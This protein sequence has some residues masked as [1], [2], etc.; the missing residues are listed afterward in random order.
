M[1]LLHGDTG[2]E[3]GACRSS[4]KDSGPSV[5][6]ACILR[7]LSV[8]QQ[9][10]CC[11]PCLNGTITTFIKQWLTMRRRSSATKAQ[12]GVSST[13]PRQRHLLRPY[14]FAWSH[15]WF[16]SAAGAQPLRHRGAPHPPLH[17]GGAG[18]AAGGGCGRSCKRSAAGKR[19]RIMNIYVSVRM[20]TSGFCG[21]TVSSEPSSK[22]CPEN[23]WRICS[24]QRLGG[25][26]A[27]R[28]RRLKPKDRTMWK[29]L[30]ATGCSS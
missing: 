24:W 16:D 21:V 27:S 29:L 9:V 25:G 15:K 20:R 4:R 3:K 5:L 23:S 13:A 2:D 22:C 14:H 28:I 19:A 7:C 10:A 11:A 17:A 8:H 6:G 30:L 12:Q 1:A 26:A 18:A